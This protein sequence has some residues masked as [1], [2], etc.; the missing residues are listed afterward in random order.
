M[1]KFACFFKTVVECW[2]EIPSNHPSK[3]LQTLRPLRCILVHW[4]A[5]FLHSL[6][7]R[8]LKIYTHGRSSMWPDTWNEVM[9]GHK[10]DSSLSERGKFVNADFFSPFF[11]FLPFP[12]KKTSGLHIPGLKPK[13]LAHHTQSIRLSFTSSWY[14]SDA[15][16]IN[17]QNFKE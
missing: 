2:C 6:S 3:D 5:H 1:L 11:S 17:F 14:H 9:Q 4:T 8:Y 15:L 16:K 7:T 10:K 12:T 13:I